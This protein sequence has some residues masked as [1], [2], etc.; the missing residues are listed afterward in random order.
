MYHLPI[1]HPLMSQSFL[2]FLEVFHQTTQQQL[3]LFSLLQFPYQRKP[4]GVRKHKLIHVD[5]TVTRT[6]RQFNAGKLSC[7]RETVTKS[8]ENF[9]PTK[10]MNL[11]L[12]NATE[13]LGT[14]NRCPK[15]NNFYIH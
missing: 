1:Y 13:H 9:P 6:V 7:M 15:F 8:G 12:E 11:W 10:F 4:V 14:L 5:L 3:F 2:Q